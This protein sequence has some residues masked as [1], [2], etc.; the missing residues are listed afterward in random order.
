MKK[1][2]MGMVGGGPDAFIGAIHRMAAQLD[3]QIEL[4][5]GVFSSTPQRSYEY[6]RHLGLKAS[7]C[8]R[9]FNDMLEQES[10]LPEGEKMELLAIVT[11]NHL[12]F[13]M[14]S[15]AIKHGF[16]VISDKPA[17]ISLAQALTL[18]RQLACS[19]VLYALTYTYTG[20]P[21]V[22]E[23]RYRVH[24][25]ELGTVRKI[26][27]S[28]HQGWLSGKNAESTKQA[29]WRLDPEQAGLSCCM[30]DI[31]VHAANLAEYISGQAITHVCADLDTAY[32]HRALDDDGTVL[33]RF[34]DEI[35]GVLLASQVA[36]GEENNLSISVYGDK[37]S[38]KWQQ[39]SP[40]SLTLRYAD[41]STR[42]IRSGVANESPLAIA[43]TRLP[44]GHPEGY[45]EAFAN[46]YRNFA[47]QIRAKKSVQPPCDSARDVPGIKEGIRGMAFIDSVVRANGSSQKWH[48]VQGVQLHD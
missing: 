14:A 48:A 18:A 33:L 37:G 40:N 22:K 17:T 26:I 13:Q 28:Y 11:P 27:V 31:G 15:D 2:K 47:A 4:V 42:V 32:E 16:H 1:I 39:Q 23:A 46:L 29:S 5:C 20:Y 6:G 7:R 44:A 30:G 38:L 19:D 36:T 8:Y 45:V 3:G 43:S 41:S 12:H 24:A 9:H 10:S 35:K 34:G 21:M 25:G